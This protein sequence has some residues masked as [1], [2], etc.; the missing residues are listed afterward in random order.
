MAGV[1]PTTEKPRYVATTGI[2]FDGLKGKPRVEAGQVIPAEVSDKEIQELL[3]SG[4][5]KESE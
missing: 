5:I 1:K 2:N 4:V 3:A